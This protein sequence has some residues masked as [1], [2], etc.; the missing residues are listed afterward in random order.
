MSNPMDVFRSLDDYFFDR[1]NRMSLSDAWRKSFI[2]EDGS[3]V[4]R[5]RTITEEFRVKYEDDG[6]IKYI[7]IKK[8]GGKYEVKETSDDNKE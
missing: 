7:P 1:A 2:P 4:K 3:I 8:D 5:T 6:T